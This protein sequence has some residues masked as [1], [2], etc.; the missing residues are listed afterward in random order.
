MRRAE[1]Q[2]SQRYRVIIVFLTFDALRAIVIGSWVHI[3]LVWLDY[4]VKKFKSHR[5]ISIDATREKMETEFLAKKLVKIEVK[6]DGV[7]RR[8]LL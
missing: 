5:K 2:A 4:T 7:K 8:A 6:F 1:T 3:V